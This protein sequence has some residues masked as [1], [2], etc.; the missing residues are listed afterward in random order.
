MGENAAGGGEGEGAA[1][2]QKGQI[3]A[4]GES[5]EAHVQRG[6]DPL[7]KQARKAQRPAVP[8]AGERKAGVFFQGKVG[9][10]PQKAAGCQVHAV[11]GKLGAGPAAQQGRC[12]KLLLGE[13]GHRGLHGKRGAQEQ[14]VPGFEHAV[15]RKP[16]IE[17][18]IA[19]VHPKMGAEG[20]KV[21]ARLHGIEGEG[22]AG[23]GLRRRLRQGRVLGRGR[24]L[25][26]WRGLGFRGGPG[27]RGRLGFRGGFGFRGG[28]E[29]RGRLGFRRG[30]RFRGGLGFQ[31]RL[32]PAGLRLQRS[33]RFR[34]NIGPRRSFRRRRSF[35]LRGRPG[36]G[37]DLGIGKRAGHRRTFGFRGSGSLWR[38]CSRQ[39]V[40]CRGLVL[41]VQRKVIE[42]AVLKAG[43]KLALPVVGGGGILV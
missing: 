22:L 35:R 10:L 34:G 13:G 40:L 41:P 14:T 25:G 42:H 11:L 7:A 12:G 4:R 9:L 15:G 16:V 26:R 31:G 21:V 18:Q 2:R 43:K 24:S 6:G 23:L 32:G 5:K 39:I 33:G 8:G 19:R 38:H 27:L 30:F 37:R 20:H 29:F 17:D 3:R 1:V 36:L 28:L